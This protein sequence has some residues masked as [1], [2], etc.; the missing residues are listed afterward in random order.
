MKQLLAAGLLIIGS[1]IFFLCA[2]NQSPATPFTTGAC[3]S[4]A[5][6]FVT[7]DYNCNGAGMSFFPG[8]S[9]EDLLCAPVSSCCFC[10][11][12][13]GVLASGAIIV[14]F[15]Y[16]AA[17]HYKRWYTSHSCPSDSDVQDGPCG[18]ECETSLPD[19]CKKQ[20]YEDCRTIAQSGPIT[21]YYSTCSTGSPK[22]IHYLGSTDIVIHD[23]AGEDTSNND[24]TFATCQPTRYATL[25]CHADVVCNG[26]GTFDVT[27]ATDGFSS[28]GMAVS[29][30]VPAHSWD[31]VWANCAETE[32]NYSS[33]TC[34][35]GSAA[36]PMSLPS[37]LGWVGDISGCTPC[38]TDHVK[39]SRVTK[40]EITLTP[41]GLFGH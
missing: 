17:T 7:E 9:C 28:G 32:L 16:E 27:F 23:P 4:N 41:V 26:N 19:G 40:H 13:D 38:H 22:V 21:L 33:T 1:C 15:S 8:V 11:N 2:P 5:R 14:Q 36:L 30:I 29:V 20:S 39:A 35:K 12:G 24:G 34:V 6:C 10:E 18:I 25:T 31:D 37:N 3:C